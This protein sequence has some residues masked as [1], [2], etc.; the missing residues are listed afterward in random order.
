MVDCAMNVTSALGGLNTATMLAAASPS[1]SSSAR[2]SAGQA[3]NASNNAASANGSANESLTAQDSSTAFTRYTSQYR[4]L[5]SIV[6]DK[7]GKYDQD[8]QL[9]AYM[10]LRSMAVSGKLKGMQADDQ[11]LWMQVNNSSVSL[12]QDGEATSDSSTTGTT[13]STSDSSSAT[14]TSQGTTTAN[15][16]SNSGNTSGTTR[17]VATVSNSRDHDTVDLSPSAQE[18]V[19]EFQAQQQS[20][21]SAQTTSQPLQVTLAQENHYRDVG[22]LISL[23]V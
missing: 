16:D 6:L 10:E 20:S 12:L 1:A 4:R 9:R 3:M 14:Y 2:G 7:D 22:T 11:R 15:S 8:Q 21:D 17:Q 19:Q 5:T 23:T 13:T 18:I